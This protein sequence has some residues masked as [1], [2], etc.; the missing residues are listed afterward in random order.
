[1][2]QPPR[3]SEPHPRPP[4]LPRRPRLQSPFR[5]AFRLSGARWLVL[6]LATVAVVAVT[7]LVDLTPR[8]ESDFFFA[9]D[10]PELRSAEQIDTL[11]PSRPQILLAAAAPDVRSSAYAAAIEE[12]TGR[13]ADLDGVAAVRSITSGPASPAAAFSGP[14]WRRLLT[15]AEPASPTGRGADADAAPALTYLIV[16]LADDPPADPAVLVERLEATVA[17]VE[18]HPPGIDPP[19]LTVSISGV[20]YVVERIR[21]AL[22]RDLKT[23]TLAAVVVFGLVIALLYRDRWI[24]AGVLATCLAACATTLALLSLAGLSIGVLTA[25]I[26]TIVFVLTLSHLIY[27][28]ANARRLGDLPQAL[29]VTGEASFWC[30]ATTLAG[31]ASLLLASAE[32][33]RELGKAG[34]IGTLVALAAA[35]GLYPPFLRRGDDGSS[36]AAAGAGD[37]AAPHDPFGGRRLGWAVAVAAALVAIAALGLPRITTDPGLLA[38]FDPGSP[39]GAGL[40]VVDESG[41][42]SPLRVLFAESE[43]GRLDSDDAL[44]RLGAVQSELE[45]DPAVGTVL[46]L[47]P[48]VDEAARTSPLAAMLGGRGLVDLLSSPTFGRV[49]QAFVTTDREQGLLF[50]R[51]RE[52]GRGAPRA[53]IVDRIEGVLRDHGFTVRATAGLFELQGQL[54]GLVASS[55]VTGLGGLFVLFA[56]VSWAVARDGR[57]AAAM[58]AC[59]AG[60]PIVLFGVLG[61]AGLPVDFIS[62]PAANVALSV[63]IDSMIHLVAAARRLRREGLA[64]CPA[65]PAW[66]EARARLARPV[67]G[68]GTILAAGFGLFLLSSFPPTRRFGLAVVLGIG[69]ATVFTLVVLPWLSTAFGRRRGEKKSRQSTQPA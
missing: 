50:L 28:T 17:E 13:L 38:Y 40:A 69:A 67:A 27:L 68:A 65:W 35:Y 2:E 9:A 33:L 22:L 66:V 1:M 46:S 30:M 48:L 3:E 12:L 29:R 37:A 14:F 55:L 34:S 21:R 36:L 15:P 51:M 58:M 26:V 56:G 8:V 25:N 52:A 5:A 60:T 59:L 41:G 54:A 20:P 31:F 6:G 39:I 7:L 10:A 61:L 11:F 42:S 44:T 4:R 49:A 43:G 24:V 62:S 63:G 53:R 18:A 47:A 64:A 32:P 16:E 45:A 19:D 57:T 23:F